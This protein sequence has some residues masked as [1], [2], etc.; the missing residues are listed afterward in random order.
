MPTSASLNPTGS[1]SIEGWIFPAW[2]ST[3]T[4]VSPIFYKWSGEGGWQRTYAFL[5]IGTHLRFGIS[6]PGH[7]LD[8]AFHSFDGP[9]NSLIPNVWNHVAAVYDQSTGTR[10]IYANGV[11]VAART[12][13][14]ITVTASSTDVTIGAFLQNPSTVGD[15]FHGSID[16]IAFYNR[17]LSASELLSIYQAGSA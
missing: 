10:R 11:E 16:E 12:D 4:A 5:A 15:L 17:A 7:E 3:S 2:D 8:G 1:F 9:D 6:D 13:A 14:P